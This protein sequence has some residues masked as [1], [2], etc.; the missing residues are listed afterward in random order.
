MAN[1]K[2]DVKWRDLIETSK[3][4]EFSIN[5][6]KDYN[7]QIE[8]IEEKTPKIKKIITEIDSIVK[9]SS[10]LLDTIDNLC[11]TKCLE[12]DFV[13]EDDT[14]E[15]LRLSIDVGELISTSTLIEESIKSILNKEK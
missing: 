2:T 15:Y 6:I 8:S 5:R 10:K 3:T 12:S 13:L 14:V 11:R 7:T 4:M 1:K 9:E